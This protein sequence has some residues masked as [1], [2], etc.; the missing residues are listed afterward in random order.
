MFHIYFLGSSEGLIFDVAD[1]NFDTALWEP[2]RQYLVDLGVRFQ[3]GVSVSSITSGGGQT[4]HVHTD[5]GEQLDA[6]A[7]VLATDV[8]GLQRIVAVVAGTRR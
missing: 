1:A 4:F 8:A 3:Q 7:V 6:D 5:A 2:L